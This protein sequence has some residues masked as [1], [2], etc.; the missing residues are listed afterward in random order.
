MTSFLVKATFVLRDD[1]PNEDDV[2]GA[3]DPSDPKVLQCLR[4][5]HAKHSKSPQWIKIMKASK[6]RA[7]NGW[8]VCGRPVADLSFERK[9]AAARFTVSRNWESDRAAETDR[10]SFATLEPPWQPDGPTAFAR[11]LARLVGRQT[12]DGTRNYAT[13]E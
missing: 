11:V 3:K 5:P 1:D 8:T 10:S 9:R 12:T 2:V 13:E 4:Q 6:C 7:V